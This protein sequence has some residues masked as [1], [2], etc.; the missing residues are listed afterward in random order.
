MCRLRPI[1]L[2]RI[3]GLSTQQIRNYADSGILPPTPR[4][5]AGYRRFGVRH[6]EALL[7][8]RALAA[9]HGWDAAR[10][11]MQAVHAGDVPRA[12]ALVDAGHAGLHDQREALES[13]GRALEQVSEGRAAVPRGDLRIGEVARHLGVRA[14]ALRVWE[15]EGLLAPRREPGT[16]YRLYGPSDVRDARMIFMLRQARHPLPQIR[17]VLDGLRRTGSSDALRAAI[18]RRRQEL[19]ARTAAM[20]AGAARLHAYLDGDDPAPATEPEGAGGNSS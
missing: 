9:G 13:T 2:A 15:A 1:D 12:L 17:P 18:A 5:P 10:A 14:S 19:T 16:G 6:R 20:L 3:A 11:I 4:T 7:T 8:Y